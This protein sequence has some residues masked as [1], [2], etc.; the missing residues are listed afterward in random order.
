MSKYYYGKMDM[1]KKY[2]QTSAEEETA[3][4]MDTPEAGSKSFEPATRSMPELDPNSAAMPQQ[5]TKKPTLGER[6]RNLVHMIGKNSTNIFSAVLTGVI[7]VSL[8]VVVFNGNGIGWLFESKIIEETGPIG[9][10]SIAL[11]PLLALALAIE[12]SVE[13]LFD[14]FEGEVENVATIANVS[15]EGFQELEDKLNA[16]WQAVNEASSL[17]DIELF[18]QAEAKLAS[19][20]EIFKGF[21][22]NPVYVGYKRRMSIY[23]GFMLGFIVAIFTD[24][25]L[26]EYLQI[27][28]PRI[29]DMLFTGA[30][31]GAGAGPMHSLVGAL[32]GLKSSLQAFG[33]QRGI[34]EV[35][36]EVRRMRA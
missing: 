27:G 18:N 32:D 24:Q 30:A 6:V 11:A 22:K 2:I 35:L 16:A 13:T 21:N 9:E 12:R 10:L 33:N 3:M 36:N 7:L 15:K 28:V 25:G 20:S 8:G 26:F 1:S 4:S 5:P 17:D 14:Y 23:I 31:L 29:V 19:I 34:D